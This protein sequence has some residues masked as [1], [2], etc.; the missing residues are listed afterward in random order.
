MDRRA[1]RGFR[2]ADVMDS[3]DVPESDGSEYTPSADY[4][5]VECH[6]F[7]DSCLRKTDAITALTRIGKGARHTG[8]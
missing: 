2:D 6:N 3:V 7:R 4:S 5:R 1:E 8:N